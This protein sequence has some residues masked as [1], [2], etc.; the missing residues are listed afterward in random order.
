MRKGLRTVDNP[1]GGMGAETAGI[2]LHQQRRSIAMYRAELYAECS[3]TSLSTVAR[4][5]RTI[6]LGFSLTLGTGGVA[7]A[8]CTTVGNTIVCTPN[9]PNPS[10][11]RIGNGPSTPSGT[12]VTVQSGA[13]VSVTNSN[14]ITLGDNATITLEDN[15]SVV[16]N[17]A[18]GNGQ[19][20]AGNNT[21][22]FGSNGR[23]TIGVGP[24]SLQTARRT[25]AN[26]SM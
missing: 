21:I 10:T 23:L 15:S 18:S 3:R 13:Q 5:I 25:T 6:I 4:G 22:E 16:N 24:P 20:N 11:T 7:W 2:L 12:T 17:A 9:P 14:A 1:N 8:N 19:W 26:R